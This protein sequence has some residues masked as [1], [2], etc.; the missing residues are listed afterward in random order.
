MEPLISS[1]GTAVS[2]VQEVMG[3]VETV[4]RNKKRCRKL[5]RRVQGIGGLL[6]EL[7]A[8]S[9]KLGMA[10]RRARRRMSTACACS[11]VGAGG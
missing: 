9:H 8:V 7:D 10:T 2:I 1:V 6:R 4:N 5:A 11:R 3:A